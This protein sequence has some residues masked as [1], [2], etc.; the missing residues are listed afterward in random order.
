[1]ARGSGLTTL[2]LGMMT[3]AFV[4]LSFDL[5]GAIAAVV[6]CV[7]GAIELF[8]Q[9]RLLRAE[10]GAARLLMLNQLALLACIAIYCAVQI[11]TFSVQ[12]VKNQ[13]LSPNVRSELAATPEITQ[14][15]DGSIDRYAPMLHYGFYSVVLLLSVACQGGMALYYARRQR[16]LDSF[17]ANTPPWAMQLLHTVAN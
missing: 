14:M 4:A 6:L 13:A 2:I 1:M 17:R 7:V 12:Q 15:V 16:R 3:A 11:A 10:P 9:R 5:I 8:G